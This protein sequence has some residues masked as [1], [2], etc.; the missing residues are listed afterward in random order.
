MEQ[1]TWT[2]KAM[3]EAMRTKADEDFYFFVKEVCEFGVNPD[4]DGPRVSEDQKELC[5]WLQSIYNGKTNVD[6]TSWLHMILAP[7]DTLKSTV[8]QAFALWAAVKNP[9]VRCLFYGEVHEQAQK[10]LSVIK[11][12]ITS[13][14]T[15]K[16]CYG[17]LDGSIQGFP[18]NENL[19][20]LSNR[21]NTAIR[22]GT[23]ETAGLDVVINARHFDWI[24]PDD[25][26]SER[27]TKTR[28]QIENVY[29]KVQLLVP[30]LTKGGNMVFAGVFWNDSDFH[31]RLIEEQNPDLFKRSVYTNDEQT[32]S[33]YPIALP[34][35]ELIK[36]RKFMSGDQFSCHYLLDPVSKESQKFKKEQFTIIPDKDF[37]SHRTFLLIDPAGDPTSEKVE[38]KDS[39]YFGMI[40]VGINSLMDILI[41][42]MFME[43]VNPTEAIEAAI[44]L[45][46]KYNP[47]V[48]G[49]ERSGIG[50]MRHYLEEELRKRGRFAIIEDLLPM[51]R[52]K[53]S[54]I[55]QLEPLA[56]RRKIYIANE[57]NYK[58]DFFDQ[59]TKVTNG[60]KSKHDD[61]IDPLAY[62]LDLLKSYGIG[63]IDT[64]RTETIP[65]EYKHLD[66]VSRD[67]WMSV[68]RS[69]D[70]KTEKTWASE[71]EGF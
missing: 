53:Y 50:N 17:N 25:L 45:I 54:R 26:H 4:P 34:V 59:I 60:I 21:K 22:E 8:L 56:R 32:I 35:K 27:N 3:A 40:V 14:E 42:N 7:R 30:L 49:I 36:K 31:T 2:N 9:D 20:V 52:S 19:V 41:R 1:I 5:E 37:D 62:I 39:D 55:I 44:S 15:F 24:F 71:F 51:A 33:R 48:I 12:I 69:K 29:E 13:C 66:A 58:E 46:L 38:R 18:W 68:K 65:S 23:I 70:A 11:R 57:S 6:K 47:Y 43:R 61:L 28:T 64:D 10:R 67:Y 16:L 63:V